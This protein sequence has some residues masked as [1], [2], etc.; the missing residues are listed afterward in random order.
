[1][2]DKTGCACEEDFHI[3]KDSKLAGLKRNSELASQR[4]HGEN[5]SRIILR[6][7]ERGHAKQQG[8]LLAQMQQ[9]APR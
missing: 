1:M 3:D 9:V 7:Q 2:A 5:S 4:V 8:R 6:G